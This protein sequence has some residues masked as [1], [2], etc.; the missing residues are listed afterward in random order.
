[1]AE[2]L[3]PTDWLIRLILIFGAFVYGTF[4]ISSPPDMGRMPPSPDVI[5]VS[6]SVDRPIGVLVPMN[7]LPAGASLHLIET[8]DIL[9]MES[10]PMQVALNVTGYIP[11]GCSAPTEILQSRDG[12]M[13]VIR[14]FRSLPPDAICTAMAA[15][16]SETI[17]V[18]GGFT[19]GNY[20][21]DVNGL[22]VQIDL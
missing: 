4:A 16:Y 9:V 17:H 2:P 21:F 11:D 8:V 3:P 7:G 6:P 5:V 19:S 14:V 10:F 20:T 15:M 13:V 1:M 18:E 22:I 12:N